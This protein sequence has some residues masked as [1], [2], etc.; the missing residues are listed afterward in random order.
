MPSQPL[1]RYSP[2]GPPPMRHGIALCSDQHYWF[3]NSSAP[4]S[5]PDKPPHL[6]PWQNRSR[7][8]QMARL[9][10]LSRKS[11]LRPHPVLL[12]SWLH[13]NGLEGLPDQTCLQ[14][15]WAH[16]FALSTA[17]AGVQDYECNQS[18]SDLSHTAC[19]GLLGHSARIQR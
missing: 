9:Q 17:S 5:A 3:E 18:H 1:T 19:S 7:Q 4:I 12:P 8:G 11:Q 14:L 10:T 15:I 2:V 6:Y 16:R 13:G